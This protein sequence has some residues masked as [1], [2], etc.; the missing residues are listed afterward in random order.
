[1]I[2]INSQTSTAFANLNT[3]SVTA[4]NANAKPSGLT[5]SQ[6]QALAQNIANVDPASLLQA[7]AN[8]TTGYAEALSLID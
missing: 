5:P 4:N 2:S 6:A 7:G 3:Q 8:R 1:M